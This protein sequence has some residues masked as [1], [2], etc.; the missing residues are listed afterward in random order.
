MLD[1][2]PC[3]LREVLV[4]GGRG[5]RAGKSGFFSSL[6]STATAIGDC[7]AG[8]GIG[9]LEH[10]GAGFFSAFAENINMH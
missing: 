2:T 3:L 1:S 6:T 9:F 7:T 8:G 5:L 10:T 4:D